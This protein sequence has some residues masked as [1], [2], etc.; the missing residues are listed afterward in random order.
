M[1]KTTM[2]I[3][4]EQATKTLCTRTISIQETII[5][6]VD[7]YNYLGHEIRIH[8]DNQKRTRKELDCD[9]PHLES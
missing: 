2:M 4:L 6:E 1:T 8:R 7:E 3:E 5:E 9:E